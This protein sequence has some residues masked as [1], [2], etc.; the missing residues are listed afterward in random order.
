[1][2]VTH[3]R[4]GVAHGVVNRAFADFAALDVRDG[5][6]QCQSH[7]GGGQHLVA[8][9]DQEQ[10]VRPQASKQIGQAE[11]GNANGLGHSDVAIGAEQA[12]DARVDGEAVF[13]DLLERVAKLRR[14]VRPEGDDSQIYGIGL[15]KIAQWPVEMTVVGPGGGDD[16]YGPLH[17]A[18]G[19]GTRADARTTSLGRYSG[20]SRHNCSRTPAT[21]RRE[22]LSCSAAI[23]VSN[24][25]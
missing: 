22:A 7:G 11:D 13:L 17:K 18:L 25:S 21:S 24:C 9:R 14:K 19:C 2:N 4:Q 6:A 5:N 3:L 10:Q 15:R 8:V 20:T 23:A 1:M 16:S 12:F